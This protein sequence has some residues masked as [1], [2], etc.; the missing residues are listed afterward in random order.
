MPSVYYLTGASGFVGGEIV[1]ALKARSCKIYAP[2]RAKKGR[3]GRERC[4]A[5]FGARVHWCDPLAK[6]PADA[7]TVVL[8]A[9]DVAFHTDVQRVLQENVAPMFD[10]GIDAARH[11]VVFVSTAYVQPPLPVRLTK[12]PIDFDGTDDP[13]KASWRDGARGTTSWA[14]RATIRTQRRTRTSTPKR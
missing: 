2:I 10:L 7:E 4:N 6:V 12:R 5:L 11:R 14:I 8:C 13:E 9:F 3:S 1:R